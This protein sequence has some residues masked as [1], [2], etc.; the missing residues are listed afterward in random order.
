MARADGPPMP[1]TYSTPEVTK[2]VVAEI[3][4]RVLRSGMNVRAD[5]VDDRL[6]SPDEIATFVP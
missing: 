3:T 4:R 6:E 1:S 2:F 5:S